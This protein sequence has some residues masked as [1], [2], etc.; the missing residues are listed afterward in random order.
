MASNT[1]IETTI[2]EDP[3]G[4]GEMLFTV[5]TVLFLGGEFGV[6]MV[7]ADR[8]VVCR[9]K[10]WWKYGKGNLQKEGNF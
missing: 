9:A 3:E 5:E 6:S 10:G 8:L 2:G 4:A 1:F 7:N